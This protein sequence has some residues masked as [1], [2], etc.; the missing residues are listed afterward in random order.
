MSLIAELKRRN[1]FRVSAAYLALGWI[2]TQVTT[3][4]APMLH[5]PEW[6]G[7]VVLWIGMIGFPFVVMFAWIYELTPE[8]LKRE[9]EVDRSG[10]ITHHTGR[11]LDYVIIGLLVLAIGLF[12]FHE[13]RSPGN[14]RTMVV[15]RTTPGMAPS[16]AGA[17]RSIAVL[18]FVNM[19]A[20]K[21]QEYF[22]DGIAEELLNLL[23]KIPQLRVIAR[24]SSFSFKGQNLDVPEIA[25]RL[26][27]TH[28]LEGSVRKAGNQ[29][30]ITAQL[31]DA[32]SDMHLWSETYDRPLDNIFAVQDEIAAA[33]V[34]QLKITL[35]GGAPKA[36]AVDPHA[37]AL[38]L[39]ARQLGRQNTPEAYERSI[40][41]YQQALTIDA[42]DAAA[43]DGLASNYIN[44]ATYGLGPIEDGYRLA[45][46]A[47]GKALAID[48]EF[49]PAHAELGQIAMIY[50]GDLAAA[51]RHFERALALEPTNTDIIRGA[52]GLLASLGR[53]DT[54]IALDEYVVARD[55]VNPTGHAN[56]GVY[57]LYAGRLDAAIESFRT[58]LNLSPDYGGAQQS[59]GVTLL[60]KGDPAGALAAMRKDANES[61]RR[62]GLPMAWHALGKKSQSDATLAE[63][64]QNDGK[65][66]AYNI[67]YVLAWRGEI[68]RAFEWLD[69]A[70]AYHDAGLSEIVTN[71]LFANLRS[72]PRWVPFLRKIGKAP[73]QLA[74][75]KFD[76][77][78]PNIS[79]K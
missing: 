70:V 3:T 5:L 29:V 30:R 72:D 28:V 55:P 13:F 62:I 18:P 46:D 36:R 35:L 22:A 73:E 48:P 33:V 42:N 56:L 19:S 9:S 44:Q 79:P 32:R 15:A 21:E 67:A 14:S 50:D 38:Y 54:A 1:V 40:A 69:K 47:V 66:W 49:A 6:V 58:A 4:V 75:I 20:D 45:R 8:G 2:V 10:S 74:A 57:Y 17:D 31:I 77:K 53:L 65:S 24:T 12:A 52:A 60:L 41:L 61:W 39:Q 37:Y 63:L 76:V 27:A 16:A 25:K 23:T 78:V 7:P 11:R 68:D 71:P 43:W 59:I 26:H 51:A 64:I 34:S